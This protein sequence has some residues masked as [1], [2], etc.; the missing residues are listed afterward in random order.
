MLLD[1]VLLCSFHLL[2]SLA[3]AGIL[4]SKTFGMGCRWLSRAWFVGVG[5]LEGGPEE[6]RGAFHRDVSPGGFL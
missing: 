2:S 4:S 1:Q 6:F 5:S 3:D